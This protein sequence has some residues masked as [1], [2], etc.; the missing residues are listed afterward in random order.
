[1]VSGGFQVLEPRTLKAMLNTTSSPIIISVHETGEDLFRYLTVF[2]AL[3]SKPSIS[4]RSLLHFQAKAIIWMQIPR[5]DLC[6]WHMLAPVSGDALDL[7][8]ANL[9][10]KATTVFVELNRQQID[11]ILE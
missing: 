2:A 6:G 4:S 11:P 1:M 3:K 5:R 9:H 8:T 7:T 10:D